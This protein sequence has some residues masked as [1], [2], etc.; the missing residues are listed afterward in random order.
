MLVATWWFDCLCIVA[1]GLVMCCA[2]VVGLVILLFDFVV[3]L[4]IVWVGYA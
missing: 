4:L 2:F 3:W 1:F